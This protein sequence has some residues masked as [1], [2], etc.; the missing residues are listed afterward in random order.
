MAAPNR[1]LERRSDIVSWLKDNFKVSAGFEIWILIS[2]GFEFLFKFQ[3]N[4]KSGLQSSA[5]FKISFIIMQ[6]TRVLDLSK[7]EEVG[8]YLEGDLNPFPW[9]IIEYLEHL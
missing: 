2:T 7:S 1:R 8:Q 4:S 9:F 6:V 3:L 5:G